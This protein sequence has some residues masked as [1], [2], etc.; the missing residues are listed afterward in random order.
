MRIFIMGEVGVGKSHAAQHLSKEGYRVIPDPV[1]A[2]GEEF[3]SGNDSLKIQLA[4]AS[5]LYLTA[6]LNEDGIFDSCLPQSFQFVIANRRLGLISEEEFTYLQHT[7]LKMITA[8]GRGDVFI[9]LHKPK[10]VVKAQIKKRGRPY[11][12]D[13]VFIDTANE[14]VRDSLVKFTEALGMN[15]VVIDV[16]KG[17]DVLDKLVAELTKESL[18][19]EDK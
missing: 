17:Y 14:V 16:T 3:L 9:Y 13:N 7:Y 6:A 10:D 11:E 4:V 12:Q 2:L 18:N 15:V 5:Q 8:I 19:E 1:I